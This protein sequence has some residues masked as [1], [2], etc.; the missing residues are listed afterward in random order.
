MQKKCNYRINKAFHGLTAGVRFSS[1]EGYAWDFSSANK[2]VPV[3]KSEQLELT[4]KHKYEKMEKQREN[5]ACVDLILIRLVKKHALEI[6]AKIDVKDEASAAAA[7]HAQ[8]QAEDAAAAAA[9]AG[10]NANGVG[11]KRE[12]DGTNGQEATK[13]QK[14]AQQ[15]RTTMTRAMKPLMYATSWADLRASRSLAQWATANAS[16]TAIRS[17]KRLKAC[18]IHAILSARPRAQRFRRAPININAFSDA[19]CVA[20]FRFSKEE[21]GQLVEVL[22]LKDGVQIREGLRACGLEAACIVRSKLAIPIRWA[23]LTAC[24]RRSTSGLSGVLTH[25]VDFCG[26]STAPFSILVSITWRISSMYASA[27][28]DAGGRHAKRVGIY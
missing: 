8:A 28:F 24:F 19:E 22:E 21:L 16:P 1:T 27:V 26:S 11:V 6:A 13:R 12:D 23:D 4:L 14:L 25:V 5:S 9:A 10:A 17:G 7:Q 3:I 15:A 2:K 18:I 20:M